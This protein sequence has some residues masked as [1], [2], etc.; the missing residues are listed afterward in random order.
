MTGEK[1]IGGIVVAW[2]GSSLGGHDGAARAARARLRRCESPVDA[3]AIE[4][5]HELNECLQEIGQRPCPDRLALLA[6]TFARLKGVRGKKLAALFGEKQGRDGPRLLSELRF[7]SLIRIRSHRHL[8]VPLRRSLAVLGSDPAC[9]GHALA[10]NLYWW[11][12]KVR[13]N[14][15]FQYFGAPFA[16]DNQ[17]ETTQ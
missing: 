4:A 6:T 1:S 2:Y 16:A 5:T 12:E 10:E 3:F 14:W 17:E 11:S 13:N 7:Q 9:D 15:C 8:I